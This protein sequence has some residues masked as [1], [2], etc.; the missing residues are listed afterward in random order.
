MLAL[1]V[2]EKKKKKKHSHEDAAIGANDTKEKDRKKK[3]DKKRGKDAV[4]DVTAELSDTKEIKAEKKHKGKKSTGDV[5][6]G[7]SAAVPASAAEV[8]AFL[9]KNNITIHVPTSTSPVTPFLNFA[10]LPIPDPLRTFS[11]KFKEPSP[12]QAC[13]WPPALE[14][15]DVIGIAETGSGKTLAFG[16]PALTR[17]IS[18]PPAK[19][20]PTITTLVVAPTRELALQTHEALEG[21]GKQFGIASVAVFGGVPKEGQVKMLRNLHKADSS[22][23]TRIIVGTPGRILDLMSEGACDLSGSV[24]ICSS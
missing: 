20:S 10:Q 11:A 15:K 18:S 8:S 3:K 22:L 19:S 4:M 2:P 24:L 17:L 9:T 12:V 1:E 14:G 21:L 5:S 6:S 23:V 13:T 16:I 7:S